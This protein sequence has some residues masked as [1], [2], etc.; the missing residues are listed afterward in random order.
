MKKYSY[1]KFQLPKRVVTHLYLGRIYPIFEL[2]FILPNSP[3]FVSPIF[4][5]DTPILNLSMWYI[6]P[7]SKATPLSLLVYLLSK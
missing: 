2:E 4:R 7:M 6:P 1:I 5:S 3:N